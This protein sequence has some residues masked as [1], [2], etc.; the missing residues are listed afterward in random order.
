M[1]PIQWPWAGASQRGAEGK[2]GL[3]VPS[4]RVCRERRGAQDRTCG[5][6][7]CMLLGRQF[8]NELLQRVVVGKSWWHVWGLGFQPWPWELSR[9]TAGQQEGKGFS[10]RVRQ[11]GSEP[12]LCR[13]P[14][15]YSGWA[16][17]SAHRTEGQGLGFAEP[18][19]PGPDV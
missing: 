16:S 13:A 3:S 8:T 9:E 5:R 17:G 6:R 4:Q 10:F 11:G 15:S 1:E 12:Q 7:P 18:R 2:A 14:R 19:G